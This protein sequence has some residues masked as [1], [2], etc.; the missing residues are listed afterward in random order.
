[1]LMLFVGDGV[2]VDYVII[3]FGDD[4]VELCKV[5]MYCGDDG[6]DVWMCCDCVC[7]G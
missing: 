6:C 2:W 4:D 7:V 1:M 3:I 5:V